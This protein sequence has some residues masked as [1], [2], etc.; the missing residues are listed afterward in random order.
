MGVNIQPDGKKPWYAVSGS[1]IS[2]LLLVISIVLLT[3]LTHDE[4]TV[5]G[6]ETSRLSLIESL[7]DR[8][9][10]NIDNS[11]FKTVDQGRINGQFYC[12][13]PML[14][15]LGLSAVY[16]VGKWLGFSFSDTYHDTLFLINWFGG[17]LFAILIIIFTRWR[18]TAAGIAPV[19]AMLLSSFGVFSSW[20]VSYGGII[21][22][23]V[24]AAFFLLL[25]YLLMERWHKRRSGLMLVLAG[26]SGG[27]LI[28]MEIPTGFFFSAAVGL[29]LLCR[30]K[31]RIRDIVV[32]GIGFMIP[33][34]LAGLADFTAY[35][36][37]LPV[38]MVPGA[39]DFPGNIHSSG[40]AGLQKPVSRLMYIVDMIFW[41]RGFFSYMPVLLLIFPALPWLMRREK[42]GPG[43]FFLA[44]IPVCFCF[45]AFATGDYGGWAYGFRFLIPIIPL[46]WLWI[47][48]WMQE[49]SRR[50]LWS[51][52]GVLTAI[53]VFSSLVGAYNPWTVCKREN[54]DLINTFKFN[55]YCA[56]Y[57]YA[58]GTFIE[59]AA[60]PLMDRINLRYYMPM[61]FANMRKIQTG[62]ARS[63]PIAMV[64]RTSVS[65]RLL[66]GLVPVWG[67]LHRPVAGL[68]FVGLL[69]LTTL[70]VLPIILKRR[71]LWL[72]PKRLVMLCVP[73]LL[74]QTICIVGVC[75]ISG[76]GLWWGALLVA[77]LIWYFAV[78]VFTGKPEII[79]RMPDIWRNRK[80]LIFWSIP[81]VFGL[82]AIAGLVQLPPLSYDVL[83]YHLYIPARWIQENAFIHVPTVFSDNS[84]AFSPKNWYLLAVAWLNFLPGDS[85]ME[86]V[87]M[88]FLFF[89]AAAVGGL[90]KEC[91]GSRK[92][93]WTGIGFTMLCP[94][95]FEYSLYA[96][97]DVAC[98]GLLVAGLYWL[99]RAWNGKNESAVMGALCL[100]LA[101]GMKTAMVPFVVLPGILLFFGELR[102]KRWIS[103]GLVVI[104]FL[105]GGGI[106][107][108]G[109]LVLYGNPLFPAAVEIGGITLFAG[110]YNSSAVYKSLFHARSVTDL[111]KT[112]YTVY[113]PVLTAILAA[114]IL[115]WPLAVWKM[116]S[117]R[118]VPILIGSHC[119]VWLLIYLVVIPH[120]MQTRFLFPCL[121]TAI[122]GLV[123]VVSQLKFVVL[124]F[125][126]ILLALSYIT[127]AVY[128]QKLYSG[129][130]SVYTFE[131]V[132]II[133][134]V[135][136]LLSYLMRKNLFGWQRLVVCVAVAWLTAAVFT[137]T[138]AVSREK[139]GSFY[140][141]LTGFNASGIFN[142]PHSVTVAYSGFNRPYILMG[143]DFMKR[144]VYCNVQ[145][146][147]TD[148]F[149]QFWRK[150]PKLYST[151]KPNIYRNNPEYRK[152]LANLK[153]QNI[154]Y[155]VLSQMAP[156]ERAYL[157]GTPD[158][159]PLP[160]KQWIRY[161]DDNFQILYS[162]QRFI[163]YRVNIP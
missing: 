55:L 110:A 20:L 45:Y 134:L 46:V 49:S 162:T 64:R 125:V 143:P 33:V 129:G 62:K 40:L 16:L 93:V 148:G 102:L 47:S 83:T 155:L 24:P 32:Y 127:N 158:G 77:A 51:I 25:L 53:S 120:N 161:G 123:I 4:I 81:A 41:Q 30:S 130:I 128:R 27:M 68:L 131:V 151:Y 6:N 59:K 36:N 87:T 10:F 142:Q 96:Q 21:N 79:W 73:L 2:C 37:P 107:Y 147:Q 98:S 88:V 112:I 63:W 5:S 19:T 108:L 8:G 85:V 75:G 153:N 118:K 18:L 92:A 157:P 163:V 133:C 39:Y 67:R 69:I 132:L 13:K 145:G 101:V 22:N 14:Y 26:L 84:A 23:H 70:R 150:A 42:S 86:V 80:T 65:R 100:G 109:N 29:Y 28:N 9:E 149:Y 103:A 12:D 38:Y 7:C 154:Q 113:G 138:D 89:T 97:P 66:N 57:E 76:A 122:A 104:L 82:I 105:A 140:R 136:F 156:A 141:R 117:R 58:D 90:I 94:V 35:G 144:V 3:L 71:R 114:G 52:F 124:K 126:G 106:W 146:K 61:A 15:P 121:L 48:L 1:M 152:W 72:G 78:R 44:T 17:T 115:S 54:R 160:E 74:F 111:I 60:R 56:A 139:R 50:W 99:I 135:V 43:I 31:K 116:P 119:F 137:G 91:G 95:I 34:F 159:F 11:R